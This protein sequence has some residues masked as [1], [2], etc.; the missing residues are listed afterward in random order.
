MNLG[1]HVTHSD[2][3]TGIDLKKCFY[4]YTALHGQLFAQPA[5]GGS[6]ISVWF[7]LVSAVGR[8]YS[9]CVEE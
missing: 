2:H 6:M 5:P 1:A 8:Y 7:S 9:N 3:E 4:Q